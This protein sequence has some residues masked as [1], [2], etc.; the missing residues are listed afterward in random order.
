MGAIDIRQD[1][2]VLNHAVSAL[3]ISPGGAGGIGSELSIGAIR[4]FGF[5]F[6]PGGMLDTNGV[7]ISINSNPALFTLMNT[8][9]GGDGGTTFAMPDLQNNLAIGQ[10]TGFGLTP[11][12]VGSQPGS[13]N[14]TLTASEVPGAPGGGQSFNNVQESLAVVYAINTGGS[15]PISGGGSATHG[16]LGE[17]NAFATTGAANTLPTGWMA[18]EGQILPIADH[19]SL[20]SIVG[21]T[22]GGD[23]LT[24]FAL[25][26]LRGRA[27][28]GVGDRPGDDAVALGQKFGSEENTLTNAQLPASA[29]GSSASVDLNQPSL[30]LNYLVALE[31]IFP[32]SSG[33][34]PGSLTPFLGEIVT[35]AGN[36]APAGYAFAHGQLLPISQFTVLFALFGTTF[37]GDGITSFALPDLRGRTILDESLGQQ[38]GQVIGRNEVQ[39]LDSDFDAVSIPDLVAAPGPVNEVI[40]G[41]GFD[42]VI[43]ARGGDDIV[44]ALAGNDKVYG[45]GGTDT[46]DGGAGNDFLDGGAGADAMTGGTGDDLFIVDNVGDTVIEAAGEGTDRVI[47]FVDVQLGDHVENLNLYGTGPQNASGNAQDN[48]IRGNDLVNEISG[49]A[50]NDT[51]FGLGGDD[52]L[53]GGDDNDILYGGADNDTLSGNDGN[54]LL[55]GGSG[56]DILRPGNTVTGDTIL[57][58]AGI[59]TVDYSDQTGPVNV[60]LLARTAIRGSATDGVHDVENAIGSQAGD[61]IRGTNGANTL[62]G[63]GGNDLINGFGGADILDGGDGLDTLNGHDGADTLRGGGEN[64]ILNGGT[65]AD[66]MFGGTG[67]DLYFVDNI[68]D[69][70]SEVGGSGIDRVISSV[71]FTL[72]DN[73]ENLTLIGAALNG[74]GNAGNNFIRGTAANNTLEGGAGDD[75]LHGEGGVDNLIGG[76][77]DDW[78]DGGSG[79]D[80]MSGGAGNDTYV[81]D[82]INDI[83]SEAGGSGID[84]V[85]SSI[86]F[87]L[88]T[89]FEN[90]TL[91]GSAVTGLGNTG[92]NVIRGNAQDNHLSGVGGNDVLIGGG[93]AD[94]F[95]FSN[96]SLSGG[97]VQ[98]NDFTKGVDTIRFDGGV[99][100]MLSGGPNL[101]ADNFVVGTHAL[102]ADDY[103][104][105][106]NG[107]L[108][109][110]ADGSGAQAAIT[111]ARLIG[112]PVIDES[113]FSINAV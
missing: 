102:D 108:S 46:I 12:P 25:P 13:D 4:T 20:F 86:N 71:D 30:G 53:N 95:Y 99:F 65:G 1:A 70:A 47:A 92:D 60:S 10:G 44:N 68:G 94:T 109:Y 34:A 56:N 76:D 83:V 33:G 74:T 42:D 9:F 73:V 110:D 63:H 6:E 98:V 7:S 27:V 52:I 106:N 101:N 66:M 19:Q 5:N 38:V 43:F 23:G 3:G 104:V 79:A 8:V 22:Y 62:E 17:V 89:G 80:T 41:T 113:D 51:I 93:G 50:G 67:D 91:T 54:D 82:N 29:G 78:L 28:V 21:A 87:S 88:Q 31:G 57:G 81:V 14:V 96:N 59:D 105:Y 2:L 24:T 103:I 85:I 11:R 15:F 111:F 100:S 112:E 37:G 58:G 69:T 48:V 90:L 35:F 72:A 16:F 55:N 107:Y 36:F 77:N 97:L 32:S 49:L 61:E 75:T 45:S 64:D 39:L 18:A 84:R 40:N 26:D